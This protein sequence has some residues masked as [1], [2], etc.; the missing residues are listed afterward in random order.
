MSNFDLKRYKYLVS[1]VIEIDYILEGIGKQ[2]IKYFEEIIP[3]EF[4]VINIEYTIADNSCFIEFKMKHQYAEKFMNWL[5][6]YSDGCGY[7][8]FTN[9]TYTTVHTSL[10]DIYSFVKNRGEQIL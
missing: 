5:D 4:H 7:D 8:D 10:S 2:F 3:S 1:N 6:K 9:D